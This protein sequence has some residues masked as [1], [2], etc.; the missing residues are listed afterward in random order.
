[1]KPL[2]TLLLAL[3]TA[4]VPAAED[5][6]I[7]LGRF[8][9]PH[10]GAFVLYSTRSKSTL[11]YNPA[12]CARRFPPQS[13]RKIPEGLIGLE[14]GAI[15]GPDG[16]LKWDGT[17][18]AI[19]AHNRDHSLRTAFAA[20]TNWFFA[21]VDRN[22]GPAQLARFFKA[23]R[24]GNQD[25][26]GSTG[27]YPEDRLAISAD[28]QVAFLLRLYKGD[29]PVSDRTMI[30]MQ[31]VMVVKNTPAGLMRAKTGTG[32][33]TKDGGPRRPDSEMVATLGWF[34]G[35]VEHGGD[36]QIFAA[37]LSGGDNPTGQKAQA[38]VEKILASR[39][40]L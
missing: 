5:G 8:F 12:R 31:D 6:E 15:P 34:V 23:F 30:A 14:T 4:A 38:V 27:I 16:K 29:L 39:G 35:W 22:V 19:V 24:Y 2:L 40:L 7:D 13:T 3:F 11:R 26:G 1:M 36:A 21:E 17:K 25:L 28:E 32:G 18:Y 10:E 33:R 9:A 20:S 37:N